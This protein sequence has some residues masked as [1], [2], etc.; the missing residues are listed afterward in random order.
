MGCPS[1][2]PLNTR[3]TTTQQP[4]EFRLNTYEI[5]TV[6]STDELVT[7]LSGYSMSRQSASS[8][9][10]KDTTAAAG[11]GQQERPV[12]VL[13]LEVLATADYFTPNQTLMHNVPPVFVDI[14][15]DPYIFNVLPRSLVPTVGYIVVVAILSWFLARSVATWIGQLARAPDQS[16]KDQ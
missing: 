8:E 3:L 6:F 5:E 14:I 2:F 9:A 7:S 12:S 1:L 15:L 11:N 4:T 16:K 10:G 13:L